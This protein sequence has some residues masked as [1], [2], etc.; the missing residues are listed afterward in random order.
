MKFTPC[1]AL[2]G[3]A[4]AAALTA[5]VTAASA[6]DLAFS[7]TLVRGNQPASPVGRCAALDPPALTINNN[8]IAPNYARGT[9]SF[10]D[11]EL[12]A[13][14]CIR[15]PPGIGFDGRFEL[16]FDNGSIFGTR[17]SALTPIGPGLFGILGTFTITGG[18]G[19]YGE[20]SGT[21]IETGTLDR[22]NPAFA[23]TEGVLEGFVTVGEPGAML[24][25]AGGF[26]VLGL[27]LGRRRA[28]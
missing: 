27:G 25:F 12:L 8:N 22:T 17:T 18:T 28:G 4:L 1:R 13:T 5:T 3:L 7:G 15:F 23:T 19:R 14:E 21:L 9:S 2:A 26:G 6:A 24:L 11:F 16:F 20:A 10:G